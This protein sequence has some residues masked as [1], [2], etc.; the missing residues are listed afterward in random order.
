MRA[1]IDSPFCLFLILV[2][3]R[4]L[5]PPKEANGRRAGEAIVRV[6]MSKWW[7]NGRLLLLCRRVQECGREMLNNS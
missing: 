6:V 1:P 5:A 7:L 2:M 3:F 4:S